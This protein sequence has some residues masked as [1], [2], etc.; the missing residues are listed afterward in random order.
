MNKNP[1]IFNISNITAHDLPAVGGKGAN[2]G[3]LARAGLA[4]PPGFCLAT[5]T[6]S[7]F[8]ARNNLERLIISKLKKISPANL[9]AA[10]TISETIQQRIKSGTMPDE[11]I[12]AV[13]AIWQ[14]IK[15][16]RAVAVRS[17]ATCEDLPETSF[18]G[19][20]DSFL[21]VIGETAILASI[22]ACWASLFNE[23]AIIYRVM[24]GIEHRQVRMAVIIQEM[25][26]SEVSG[27]AFT[28]DPVSG[29]RG[30][31]VINS[32]YGLGEALVAGLATP[33]TYH[34]D[35]S[36]LAILIK[37]IGTKDQAIRFKA[38]GGTE[39]VP[40]TADRQTR[41]ALS[42]EA[43]LSLADQCRK[44][45][46]HFGG[47]P[48]DVEWSLLNN[49]FY[50]V[51]A[52]PI[53]ALYPPPTSHS[54]PGK[55]HL[56][57]SFNYAQVMT[58]TISPL[59]Q[60][61][62][63]QAFFGGRAIENTFLV[64]AGGRL[65]LDLTGALAFKTF[66]HHF[67]ELLARLLDPL[68][69]AELTA[70][71]NR[72]EFQPRLTWQLIMKAA[73]LL[74]LNI[75]PILAN[76]ALNIL[77][78]NPDRQ[79]HKLENHMKTLTTETNYTTAAEPSVIIRQIRQA[80]QQ[81]VPDVIRKIAP[82]VGSGILSYLVLGKLLANKTNQRDLTAVVRG[83]KNN[84]V[85]E[86]D[87]VIGDLADIL[88][89]NSQLQQAI[90]ADPQLSTRPTLEALPGGYE[91]FLVLDDFSKRFGFRGRSEIDIAR[92]RFNENRSVL[93][94]LIL[95]TISAKQPG[96]HRAKQQELRRLAEEASRR[97]E[98]SVS[99]NSRP[100]KTWLI[101]KLIAATRSYLGFREHP[102]Y[103]MMRN[104]WHFKQGLKLIAEYLVKQGAITET[105]DIYWLTLPE[106]EELIRI[107]RASQKLVSARQQEYSNYKNLTVPRFI[108]SEGEIIRLVRPTDHLPPGAL[109][110]TPVS[111]GIIEG[112]ARI[113]LDPQKQ[114]LNKGEILVT[115]FTDPGWT[116]L[117]INAA[118]LVIETGGIMTHGSIIAREYGLPALAGVEQATQ[119][120]KDGQRIRLDAD[121]GY[122]LPLD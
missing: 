45:E 115:K 81:L 14:T 75:L 21:N 112:T 9:E 17:S 2:L 122:V 15:S 91:F 82:Y 88:S 94:H 101:K 64:P 51:Q 97:I 28:A 32:S 10:K 52:R 83:L 13:S 39:Q 57:F 69:A 42:D 62:L 48:Q 30:R 56:Y 118:G 23:R 95:T 103:L 90:I 85:M 78:R 120:I 96:D 49:K 33:D 5:S 67:P 46:A 1:F 63:R 114:A 34:I 40:V 98:R 54:S 119:L 61:L 77:F 65:F 41:F 87:L 117:F 100:A 89:R 43:I 109:A 58:D 73:R 93:A 59:G 99:A 24:N 8:M 18:A 104:F 70:A 36:S 29:H 108:T 35:K 111:A 116:P 31:I 16:N 106:I 110:G 26:E 12:Q 50:I 72:P 38:G 6:Y 102:K 113:V 20:H 80:S 76:V 22:K 44:I 19:Q 55:A 60:S 92:D 105:G 68:A 27:L 4:V 86:M 37:R 79:R 71:S 11:A 84:I 7:L 25:I 53:T 74:N 47:K 66:R 121:S 3:E 107:P